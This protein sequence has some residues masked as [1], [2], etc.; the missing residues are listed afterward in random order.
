MKPEAAAS[1]AF[2]AM[3]SSIIFL[4]LGGFSIAAGLK[5]YVIS[6]SPP[7]MF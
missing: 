2:N 3:W 6:V 1:F 4:M 5:K 7:Y